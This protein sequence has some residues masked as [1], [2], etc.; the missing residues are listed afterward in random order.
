MCEDGGAAFAVGGGLIK[1]VSVEWSTVRSLIE[2]MYS[3][4]GTFM[5]IDV[6]S[7]G[8]RWT[9]LSRRQTLEIVEVH[10]DRRFPSERFG[11]GV[12]R[13]S[14]LS[15]TCMVWLT[16]ESVDHGPEFVAWETPK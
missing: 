9:G 8:V 15:S 6:T 10:M 13:C 3:G 7:N 2:D 1:G 14:M 4:G 11:V 5:V 12:V 16:S